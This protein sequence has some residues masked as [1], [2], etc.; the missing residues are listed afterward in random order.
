M[1][2]GNNKT[3][4]ASQKCIAESFVKLLRKKEY[5]KISIS[6]ICDEAGISR[7]TFYSLFS[8]KENIISFEL[9]KKY[10]FDVGDECKCCGLPTLDELSHG[11]ALFI[12]GKSEFIELLVKN[13]IIYLMQECLYE[14]F[15]NCD[16]WKEMTDGRSA[17]VTADFIAAGLTTVAK[18]YVLNR[19]D[20]QG[21]KLKELIYTLFNGDYFKR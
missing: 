7:Q 19:S 18:H 9:S 6:E 8:S 21:E 1:Y 15:V 12:E 13:N 16:G 11:Y 17:L 10:F 5:S 14:S 2:Q 3:A 4:L 20:F